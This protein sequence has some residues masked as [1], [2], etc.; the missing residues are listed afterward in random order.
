[1]IAVI[2]VPGPSTRM[3]GLDAKRSLALLP[4]GDRPV[5]QH[6][7]ESL[8]AQG[9]TSIELIISHAPE[10][11]EA[12]LGT[13]DRWGC[14]F[15]YHLSTQPQN[16]YRS[17]RVI[18]E[19]RSQPW[20]LIHGECYPCLKFDS[21]KLDSPV[22]FYGSHDDGL[23]VSENWKGT[24]IFPPGIFDDEFASQTVDEM[25][26]SIS[27]FADK[28][29]ANLVNVASWIDASSPASFLKSQTMLL[30]RRLDGLMIS[31]TE[32]ES[33]IWISRNV[34][35]HPSVI[36][37][38]PLYVGPNTRLNRGVRVG[39]NAVIEG[40]CIVDTNTSIEDSMI[41]AGS[42]VGEG[43]ELNR[44]LV[45]RNLLINARLGTGV[46]VVESFL[47]GGLKASRQSWWIRAIQSLLAVLLTLLLSPITLLAIA[48]YAL[49]RRQ[50]LTS[51][52][53]VSLPAKEGEKEV[54]THALYCIGDDAWSKSRKAGWLA[55]TRQ[56]LPGLLSVAAGRIN[57][58]GLPPR[59][60]S[61]IAEL[62]AEWREM[63]LAGTSGLITEASV[64]A[65]DPEDEV[66]RYLAD[67]YYVV[68][69]SFIY[70]LKLALRY[71]S[72]L[73]LPA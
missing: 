56:F 24:A 14:K 42:Y 49:I 39:P 57:L 58:V 69:K 16:P 22:L 55:F 44:A 52:P 3:H 28:F 30:E 62:T 60:A 38:A 11:V 46:N 72:R 1:M 65:H 41:A 66:Q 32:R 6:I 13:G 25:F 9:I 12:L 17:L 68:T 73:I 18:P 71:F 26:S 8:A 63:Y 23:T 70:N 67:A 5:L 54:K 20:V 34:V 51:I 31:G 40:E 15:K 36:L 4:L 19:L 48:F 10:A 7:V 21:G 37:T 27:N 61:E 50:G 59:T 45:D 53:A 64:A 2:I 35:V 43:L 47:L 29:K 33:G